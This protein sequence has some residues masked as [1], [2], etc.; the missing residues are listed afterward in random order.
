MDEHKQSEV[1]A[2]Y[3]GFEALYK[4]QG[5]RGTCPECGEVKLLVWGTH[6]HEPVTECFHV[7]CLDCTW[8]QEPG[9]TYLVLVDTIKFCMN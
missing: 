6:H 2:I 8:N 3:K 4:A 5:A 9:M 1:A 7:W